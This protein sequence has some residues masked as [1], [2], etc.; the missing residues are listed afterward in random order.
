VRTIFVLLLAVT[1]QLVLLAPI[2]A[3]GWNKE[4]FPGF[5]VEQPLVVTDAD[6]QG[7]S[8]RQAGIAYPQKVTHI[9][10]LPVRTAGE[11][12]AAIQNHPI[13]DEIRVTTILPDGASRSYSA[14]TWRSSRSQT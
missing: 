9:D 11:F 13:G 7:W 3:I 4:P 5:L 10:A 8:G 6:G 1:L 12:S 2:L 14:S